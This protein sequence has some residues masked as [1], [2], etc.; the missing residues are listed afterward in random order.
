MERVP[1]KLCDVL[2]YC[3]CSRRHNKLGQFLECFAL[4]S[5]STCQSYCNETR[6]VTASNPYVHVQGYKANNRILTY[7]NTV[8][9]GLGLLMDLI[10]KQ[11]EHSSDSNEGQF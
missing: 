3:A 4:G 11:Y 1:N 6:Q 2:I 8:Q 10:N 9:F 7:L 5:S